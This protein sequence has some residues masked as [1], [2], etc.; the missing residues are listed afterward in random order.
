MIDSKLHAILNTL[1]P[2]RVFP[3]VAPNSIFVEPDVQPFI[4]YTQVSGRMRRRIDRPDTMPQVRMQITVIA[5]TALSASA[6]LSGACDAIQESTDFRAVRMGNMV[7]MYDDDM[8]LFTYIQD[9]SI[10]YNRD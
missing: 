10:H 8:L 3:D 9:F 7:T 1:A 6:L 4:V 5:K 2:S